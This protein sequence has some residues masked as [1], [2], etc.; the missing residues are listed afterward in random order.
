METV[1]TYRN[2]Y[3]GGSP[4]DVGRALRRAGFRQANA[5]LSHMNMNYVEGPDKP[6]TWAPVEFPATMLGKA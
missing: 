5:P 4:S 2:P 1:G 3:E 6:K